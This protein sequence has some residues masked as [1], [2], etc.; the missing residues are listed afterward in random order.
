[1]ITK[2]LKPC[3]FCGAEP[4]SDIRPFGY[5]TEAYKELH[6]IGCNQCNIQFEAESE[7]TVK[8]GEIVTLRDGYK[9]CTEKWNRRV[10]NENKSV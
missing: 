5:S 10:D 9:K 1:M 8:N 4:I 3:P 6:V 7:Y 2:I